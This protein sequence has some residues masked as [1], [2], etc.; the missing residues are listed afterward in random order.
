MGNGR[1]LTVLFVE[2]ATFINHHKM[3]YFRGKNA[4]CIILERF[5]SSSVECLRS[6]Q[7]NSIFFVRFSLS[8]Q[9][10]PRNPGFNDRVGGK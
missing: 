4:L 5:E 1:L 8:V 3:Y 2:Y 7:R 9:A 10:R 6:P